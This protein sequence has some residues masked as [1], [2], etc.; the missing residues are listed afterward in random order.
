MTTVGG[1]DAPLQLAVFTGDSVT[2]YPLPPGGQE[3][4][5][6]SNQAVYE[7]ALELAEQV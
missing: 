4:L 2:V 1:L 5:D 3:A 6:N 7:V